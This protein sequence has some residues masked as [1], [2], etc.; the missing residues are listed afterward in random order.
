[1]RFMA[2]ILLSAFASSMTVTVT[3]IPRHRPLITDHSA[4]TQAHI[5]SVSKSATPRPLSIIND[6]FE[7]ARAEANKGKLPLFVEVWAPW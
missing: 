1:M 7:K 6:D 5:S 4:I 3:T 2:S